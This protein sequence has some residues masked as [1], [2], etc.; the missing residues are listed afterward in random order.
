MQLLR[1]EKP[2]LKRE[3]HV[4]RLAL[5]GSLARGEGDSDSDI[6]ILVDVPP[7]I[8]L[9]FVDLAEDLERTL[10]H[11]VDLVSSRGLKPSLREAIQSDLIDA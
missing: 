5:F 7:S 11:K 1:R 4:Q 9:R 3:F 8:G 2:R 10:H 6:D